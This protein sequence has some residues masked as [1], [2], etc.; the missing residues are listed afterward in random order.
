MKRSGMTNTVR[1]LVRTCGT[2]C[3]FYAGV[4]GLVRQARSLSAEWGLEAAGLYHDCARRPRQWD[5][6]YFAKRATAEALAR[7]SK[8]LSAALLNADS[9]QVEVRQ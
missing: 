2:Q 1:R 9:V 4:N 3:A 5:R 6:D 7:C 8:A